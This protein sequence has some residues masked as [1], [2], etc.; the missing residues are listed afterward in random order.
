MLT[1]DDAFRKFKSRLELND[2]EQ[3]N[4]SDRQ[5]EVREYLDT[6]FDIE[7]SFLTGST[8]AIP[9][10]NRCETSTSSLSWE[11]PSGIIAIRHPA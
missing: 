7:R 8:S 5:T 4:A 6:K 3:K 10:P 11:N 1:V 9:R 2:R